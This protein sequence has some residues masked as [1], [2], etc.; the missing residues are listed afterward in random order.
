MKK[1][2]EKFKLPKKITDIINRKPDSRPTIYAY[3]DTN[4]QYEGLLKVGYTTVDVVS[5]VK[6]QYPT[7]RPGPEYTSGGS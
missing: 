7:K 6:Q 2:L 4:P 1:L 3:L 5:R